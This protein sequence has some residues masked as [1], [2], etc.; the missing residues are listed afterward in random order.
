MF[1]TGFGSA[2]ILVLPGLWLWV[3]VRVFVGE[4]VK[5]QR[6]QARSQMTARVEIQE[7]KK[8][9]QLVEHVCQINETNTNKTSRTFNTT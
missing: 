3:C 8:N 2:Q 5:G 6:S 7:N 1:N 4:T 9:T